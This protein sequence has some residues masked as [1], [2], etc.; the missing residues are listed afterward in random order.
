MQSFW[1]YK[2]F[3]LAAAVPELR[4]HPL[5]VVAA[6]TSPGR[7]WVLLV[8]QSTQLCAA[9]LELRLSGLLHSQILSRCDQQRQGDAGGVKQPAGDLSHLLPESDHQTATASPAPEESF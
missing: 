5:L 4:F 7:R 6:Q 1:G 2:L 9:V 8:F 3:F